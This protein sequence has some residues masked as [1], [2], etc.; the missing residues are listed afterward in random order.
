MLFHQIEDMQYGAFL[1]SNTL[2]L[3]LVI[4]KEVEIEVVLLLELEWQG[5]R[6]G[7][8]SSPQILCT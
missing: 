2:Y 8:E 3:Q 1:A 6:D 7:I 4:H 5:I